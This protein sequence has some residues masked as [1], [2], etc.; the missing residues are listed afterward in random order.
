MLLYVQTDSEHMSQRAELLRPL[1]KTPCAQI[2]GVEIVSI[3]FVLS[4]V[5]IF[6]F[7][8]FKP[9]IIKMVLPDCLKS[10]VREFIQGNI[11]PE[12]QMVS[13]LQLPLLTSSLPLAPRSTR[14]PRGHWSDSPGLH[15]ELTPPEGKVTFGW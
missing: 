5:F 10:A 6:F 11:I 14:V 4:H 8:F 15:L 13:R 2:A 7:F 9:K 1:V 3:I 12:R